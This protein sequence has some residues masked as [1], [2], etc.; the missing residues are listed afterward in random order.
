MAGCPLQ[1]WKITTFTQNLQSTKA[2][3]LWTHVRCEVFLIRKPRT[4]VGLLCLC[5]VLPAV[6]SLPQPIK[7]IM[8]TLF[9]FPAD[10]KLL[11]LKSMLSLRS[12]IHGL[13]KP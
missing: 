13:N 11:K 7:A 12:N 1:L 6:V 5:G 8:P 3:T 2:L 9:Y 10:R 4:S